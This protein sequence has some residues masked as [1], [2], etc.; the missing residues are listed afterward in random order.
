MA[1]RFFGKV[2]SIKAGEYEFNGSMNLI[3][4]L[5]VLVSG[6]V[7]QHPV[8][9]PEGYNIF[10]VAA[11]LKEAGL[12]DD[13]E[14]IKRA[15][16]TVFVSSFG[17]EGAT[18]EG[19]LFPDTY[20]LEKGMSADEIIGKMAQRFKAVY[21]PK[22]DEIAR[23]S[24]VSMLRCITL[25]SIIEKETGNAGERGLISSVFH[26]RLK[27][28]I[29][30]QSDPTVIY[31]IAGFDGNLRRRDLLR[32]NPYNTYVN[33]GLPPGPIANPGRES[34]MAALRPVDGGYLYFVSKN[35]GTHYF[36]K[37]L[38]EHNNAVNTYQRRGRSSDRQSGKRPTAAKE[39]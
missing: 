29:R 31:A 25:A 5:D 34:M 12:V 36:S 35:D 23:A 28:R 22:L 11:K 37:T 4:I 17:L 6:K 9:I 27:A 15:T 7:R 18:F 1:A 26:N 19:Y 3:E 38:R 39:G 16:D 24:G 33:Y 20:M 13:G 14:F 2:R 8:V 32:K 30:L 10:E 21:F